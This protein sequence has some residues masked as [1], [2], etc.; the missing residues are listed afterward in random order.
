MTAIVQAGANQPLSFTVGDDVSLRL[1]VTENS[2]AY[3]WTGAT[4][5]TSI[6][7]N[8]AAVATNFTTATS[9]GGILDLSL[10]DT[11]TT[12]LGLGT[13]DYWVKVTK[14]SVT[15]TWVAGQLTMH[16]AQYGSASNLSSSLSITTAASTTLAITLSGYGA[17]TT[18]IITALPAATAVTAD[19]LFVIVDDPAGTP[20]SKKATAAQLASFVVGSD[21]ARGEFVPALVADLANTADA[22]AHF[23]ALITEATITLNLNKVVYLPAGVWTVTG[24]LYVAERGL[25]IRSASRSRGTTIIFTGT[26]ALFQLGTDDGLAYDAANYNGSASNFTL[27][28]VTLTTNGATALDNA[29]G[30][31]LVGSIGIKDWRGGEV[32]LRHVTIT[33]FDYSTWGVQSDLNTW[34]ECLFSYNHR[35]NYQGPRS[36]Q[37]TAVAC[38]WLLNDREVDIDS[39]SGRFIGCSFVGGGNASTNPIKIHSAWTAPARDVSFDDCWFEHYQGAAAIDAFVEV[40]VGDSVESSGIHFRNPTILTQLSSGSY[41]SKYLCKVGNANNIT[42]EHPGWTWS[43]LDY[44]LYFVGTTSPSALLVGADTSDTTFGY[45]NGGS[46][47]PKVST[48]E[49]G[50]T[51]GRTNF[52]GL[53]TTVTGDGAVAIRLA[54][55]RVWTLRQTGAAGSAQLDLHAESS[56]KNFLISS[57]NGTVPFKIIQSDTSANNYV[58]I[59]TSA[60]RI[61]L[62]GTTPTAKSSGWGAPTGVATKTTFD[63]ATVTLPQLAERLKALIDYL[64]LRGDIGA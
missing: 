9:T 7:A 30:N 34:T 63:T 51:A 43:Q 42:V 20:T 23:Q 6:I 16:A 58:Y 40:G 45:L 46:G 53:E 26:G 10:T 24:T 57:P 22:T 41:Y 33:N 17:F 56:D 49:Y 3:S 60:G 62:N 47:S 48:I 59:G 44:L 32:S 64:T 1:T 37:L 36:D 61:G 27:E 5:T 2:V 11:Q 8:G 38:Y 12:T 18:S 31:Y 13:F 50:G 4:V 19:D 25:T 21:A 29:Q 28:D 55:E 35:G 39:S 15:S 54:I 14:A 52:N